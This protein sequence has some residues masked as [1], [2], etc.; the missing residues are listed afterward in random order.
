METFSEMRVMPVNSQISFICQKSFTDVGDTLGMP[1]IESTACTK[2]H[3]AT[4]KQKND[5]LKNTKKL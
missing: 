5:N 1:Y 2:S 4:T 3:I